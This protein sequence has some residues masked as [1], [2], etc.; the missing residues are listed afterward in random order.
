MTVGVLVGVAVGVWVGVSVGV[1]VGVSVGVGNQLTLAPEST[2]LLGEITV[3]ARFVLSCTSTYE[4]ARD[5]CGSIDQVEPP[6]VDRRERSCP[7]APCSVRV[8][9]VVC[10]VPAV[11]L[12]VSAD[13]TLFVRL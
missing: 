9:V 2:E 11:K 3:A 5:P 10:V 6:D 13:A 12:S 7:A 8:P 4:I 1:E